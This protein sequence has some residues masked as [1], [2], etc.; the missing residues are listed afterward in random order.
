VSR[1]DRRQCDAPVKHDAE[2]LG[3]EIVDAC[4]EQD[5]TSAHVSDEQLLISMLS[6]P[7]VSRGSSN[8]ARSQVWLVCGI[9]PM[10][11]R[12]LVVSSLCDDAH[13]FVPNV[14][15]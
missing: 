14:A 10:T 2:I 13:A 15:A 9:D 5:Q 1:G 4:S 6:V 12:V 7:G 3:R 11:V 8:V